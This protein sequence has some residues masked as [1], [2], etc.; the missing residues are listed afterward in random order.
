[1]PKHLPDLNSLISHIALYNN[2]NAYEKLFKSLFPSLYRF[3]FYLL[4]SRELAEEVASDVMITLWRD[5]EKLTEIKNIKVYAFVIARNLSLNVLNKH[6]KQEWVSLDDIEFEIILDNLNPE[7][8]LI[9]DELKKARSS[10]RKAPSQC[11]LVFKLI[12][13]DGLSY[14]ETA[15]ILNISP[16]TV[17]AHLVTAIKKMSN[18]LKAEFNLM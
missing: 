12:K 7:Q 9:N 11:K 13:E 2:E 17:D 16:K 3:C 14:K 18:V 10:N 8:I 5:R 1:M 4:K 6:S 15:S